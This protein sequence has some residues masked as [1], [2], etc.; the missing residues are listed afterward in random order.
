MVFKKFQ[1]IFLASFSLIAMNIHASFENEDTPSS[2]SEEVLHTIKHRQVILFFYKF[3][4]LKDIF[5][6]LHLLFNLKCLTFD[7]F[8]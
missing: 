7:L 1:T 2:L 4:F 5:I 8:V 6:F 3:Y